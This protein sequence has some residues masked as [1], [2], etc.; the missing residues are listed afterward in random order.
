V[1]SQEDN[2]AVLQWEPDSDY[3]RRCV[4]RGTRL[5]LRAKTCWSIW[6]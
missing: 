6:A 1:A 2:D 3:L 5:W 4:E